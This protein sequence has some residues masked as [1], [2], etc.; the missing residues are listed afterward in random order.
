MFTVYRNSVLTP[1]LRSPGVGP[2]YSCFTNN[3]SIFIFLLYT[4]AK[5]FFG[6]RKY[7]AQE[8][9]QEIHFNLYHDPAYPR[10]CIS[11]DFDQGSMGPKV[12]ACIRF[13]KATGKEAAIGALRDAELILQGEKGTR[14]HQ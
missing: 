12:E 5:I 1:G 4:K 13:V 3:L 14:V 7:E 9:S 8:L 2:I 6:G 10:G 11:T